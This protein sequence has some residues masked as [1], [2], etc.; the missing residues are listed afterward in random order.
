VRLAE[1][2]VY[3]EDCCPSRLFGVKE[4]GRPGTG[5]RK[6]DSG[7]KK[8]RLDDPPGDLNGDHER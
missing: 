5:R 1:L 2:Y 7:R 8:G 3:I 4:R 6:V